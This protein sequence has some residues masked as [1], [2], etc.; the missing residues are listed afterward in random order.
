MRDPLRVRIDNDNVAQSMPQIEWRV[1]HNVFLLVSCADHFD[2]RDRQDG[3]CCILG[4]RRFAKD[5]NIG[6]LERTIGKTDRNVGKVI[7]HARAAPVSQW[8][9]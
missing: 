1:E 6:S 9:N 5:G 7:T 3:Q 2:N 4:W 8:R